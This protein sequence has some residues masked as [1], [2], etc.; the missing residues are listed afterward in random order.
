MSSPLKRL[1]VSPATLASTELNSLA[2]DGR[3]LGVEYDNGDSANLHLEADFELAVGFGSAPTAG[4]AVNLYL[5]PAIDGTNYGAGDGTDAAQG[6]TFVGSFS[7]YNTTSL[8]RL[9][10]MAVRIPPCKFKALIENKTGQSFASS[11]NVLLMLPSSGQ[12]G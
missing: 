7:V 5:V 3:V 1:V 2:N 10:L 6:M 11:N 9:N 12:V 4:Y 8:K